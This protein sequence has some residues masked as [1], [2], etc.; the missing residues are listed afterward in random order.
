MCRAICDIYLFRYLPRTRSM[1][2]LSSRSNLAL[3]YV[4][5]SCGF[6]SCRNLFGC[7]H[8]DRGTWNA[9]LE[10]IA[11]N[12]S[13]PYVTVSFQSTVPI[14]CPPCS[15]TIPVVNHV[16]VALSGCS[17]TFSSSDP[18]DIVKTLTVRA[19][20]T[21]GRNARLAIVL[22]GDSET[23]VSGSGWDDYVQRY[24]LVSSI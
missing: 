11:F 13:E 17:L 20:Q 18:P 8:Q 21:P 4:T 22:F 7:F 9:E 1:F 19:V 10:Y 6:R 12:E 23:E 2:T 15:L 5:R 14:S 3:T 24:L 16:G